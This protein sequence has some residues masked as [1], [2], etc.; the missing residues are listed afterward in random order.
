MISPAN[1]GINTHGLTLFATEE[2]IKEHPETV[3]R[4]VRAT[5]KGVNYVVENPEDGVKSTVKR[6]AK[7]NAETEMKRLI[8]DNSVTSV[9]GHMDYEMFKETY[10]RLVEEGIVSEGM[11][12]NN[13]FTTEFL[14]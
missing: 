11:D 8:I 12:V 4:F 2:M 7:L 5:L 9:D 13:A 3:Q 10:D 14:H 6:N 1:Y